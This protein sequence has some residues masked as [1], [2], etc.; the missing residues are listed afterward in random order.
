VKKSVLYQDRSAWEHRRTRRSCRGAKEDGKGLRQKE[1]AAK[2]IKKRE[3]RQVTIDNQRRAT[4]P[5]RA[6][7]V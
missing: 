1:Y 6:R 7:G 5:V 3:E 2:K 4:L